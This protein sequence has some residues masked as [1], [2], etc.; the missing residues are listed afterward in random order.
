MGKVVVC[1]NITLDGIAESP[2]N[3]MDMSDE[4]LTDNMDR[5]D[6]T[7]HV[8]FGRKSFAGTAAYWKNA[9]KNSK[10]EVVQG[11]VA[12]VKAA[13]KLVL[14]HSVVDTSIYQNSELFQ[15]P[16]L[17][18]LSSAI[19]RLKN[20]SRGDISVEAGISTFRY[21]I[22]HKCFDELRLTVH[23]IIFGVGKRLFEKDGK[24][25]LEL[26]DSKPYKNGAVLMHYQ[27]QP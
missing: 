27:R 21:F 20:S 19:T 7:E 2:E 9:E 18:F 26:I 14:S 3:W 8:I 1:V 13:H 10:S 16:N 12:K 25:K 17:E 15:A 23:P 4:F 6:Q 5:Y 22:E 24:I 11:F